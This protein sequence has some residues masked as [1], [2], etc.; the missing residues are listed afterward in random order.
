MFLNIKNKRLEIKYLDEYIELPKEIQNKIDEKWSE[1]VKESPTLWNGDIACVEDIKIED[2]YIT[3]SCRK[4]TY[5]HYIY[6]EKVGL[7]KEYE[8]RV[9]TAGVLFETNDN[10]FVLGEVDKSMPNP[11]MIQMPGGNI[12]KSDI[13]EG[14]IDCLKTIIRE[15]K[16]EVNIDLN[17]KKIVK[18]YALNS[19]YNA[20]EG[21]QP[22]IEVFAKAKLKIDKDDLEKHFNNYY[23][24]LLKNNHYVEIKK[25]HFLDK[26]NCI[27][28]LEKLKNSKRSYLGQLLKFN[29]S[30][31]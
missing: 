18:E 9:L 4:T 30:N 26:T 13:E 19:F 12:D 6:Q 8:C 25:L 16:E 28:E 3:L 27:E 1:I 2:N 5:S 7:P 24:S 21:F 14:H 31:R 20:D 10:Y 22:E 17:D 29:N 23:E 15:I 11:T